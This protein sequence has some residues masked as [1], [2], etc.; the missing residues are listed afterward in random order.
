VLKIINC[1]LYNEIFNVSGGFEL[2]NFETVKQIINNFYE[3]EHKDI[4]KFLDLSYNRQ[5]QDIRYSLNDNKLRSIGWNPEKI[6][7]NE[8]KNIVNT[9]K[10]ENVK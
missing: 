5:G 7:F 9:E 3:T 8:L 1:G 4:N 2:S 10:S 6:F